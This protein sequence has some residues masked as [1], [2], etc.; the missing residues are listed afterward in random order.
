MS[1]RRRQ[2]WLAGRYANVDGI[3]FKMPVATKS[4]PG[5]FAGFAVDAAAAAEMVPDELRVV[6]IKNRGLLLI[7]VVDY[8]NT[9][10][11]KYI[12]FCIG[13]AVT[14][15]PRD[16]RLL[17]ASLRPAASGLG[18]YVY[19]LPVSTEISVK[20]GLGI[21]GMPKRQASLD[22][23]INSRLIS[24]QYNLEGTMVLR[25]DIPKPSHTWLPVRSR[26][27]AWGADFRGL[28]TKSTVYARGTAGVH[29]RPRNARLMLGDHPR[30]APLRMLRPNARALF[31]A[32]AP[33]MSGVL[34]DHIETWHLSSS[35]VPAPAM[36]GLRDVVNLGLGEEWLPPPRDP[37]LSHHP[38]LPESR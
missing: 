31:T 22:F 7:T 32:Y 8:R 34:S 25:V 24:S 36:I 1:D 35:T 28:L 3:P 17:L 15:G 13:L 33:A 19:D 27:T 11:G 6:N 29:L 16:R 5:I 14:R 12:E 20:G 38:S 9:T 4:S 18:I 26:S 30:A 2:K 10:I 21:W 37:S 23:L